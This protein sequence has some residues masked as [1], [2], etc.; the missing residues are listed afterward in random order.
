LPISNRRGGVALRVRTQAALP[1]SLGGLPFHRFD[2]PTGKNGA[3]K[4]FSENPM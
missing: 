2:C 4:F 3:K 1:H